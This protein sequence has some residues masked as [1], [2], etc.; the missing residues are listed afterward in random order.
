MSFLTSFKKKTTL[1]AA[2]KQVGKARK[3]ADAKADALFK[4]AY[5]G[6]EFVLSDNLMISEALYNWGLGLLHQA[7]SKQDEAAI[8]LY[9][10]AINKFSF[11]LSMDKYYL[12]AAIDGGVAYMDLARL[13]KAD[14]NDKVYKSAKKFF[15]QAEEIQKGSASYNLACL[16]CLN[17]DNDACLEALKTS[18]EFGSLPDEAEINTDPDMATVVQSEWFVEFMAMRSNEIEA[19]KNAEV[20]R[21][22]AKVAAAKLKAD[23]ANGAVSSEVTEN[24]TT[25]ETDTKS[26]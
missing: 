20:E 16:Y 5:E 12:G 15:E 2:T 4:S 21:K 7:K 11:C 3:S 22:K 18:K 19:E 6:F 8:E 25:E 13:L 1:S 24:T 14:I 23:K 17:G 10:E 9:E 26:E